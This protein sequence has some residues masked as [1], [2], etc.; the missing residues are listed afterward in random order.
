MTNT[1]QLHDNVE[2][3]RTPFHATISNMHNVPSNVQ[4]TDQYKPTQSTQHSEVRANVDFH[5]LAELDNSWTRMY[6]K[7]VFLLFLDNQKASEA[8]DSRN[9]LVD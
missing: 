9:D 8:E 5:D 2:L 3:N 4:Q 7:S 1:N 6:V